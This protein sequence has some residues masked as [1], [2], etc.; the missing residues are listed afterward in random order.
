MAGHSKW[1][2]I[3]HQKGVADKKRGQLFSKLLVAIT[4]AAKLEA[5]PKFNPRLR[6]AIEKAKESNVPHENIERAIK[7]ASEAETNTKPILIEAYGPGGV[8]ILIEGATDNKNRTIAE[9]KKVLHEHLGKWGEAGSVR[10]MFDPPSIEGYQEW[11][12]KY[13][14]RIDDREKKDL[15]TLISA[16][17]NHPDIHEVHHN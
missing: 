10:W 13:E 16:L 12:P 7:R 1:A 3:K 8:A 9:V 11:K 17:K 6:T 4:A 5:D 15:E 2:Q 14:Q